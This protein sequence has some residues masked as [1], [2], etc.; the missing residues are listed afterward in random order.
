MT[1]FSIGKKGESPKLFTKNPIYSIC[2]KYRELRLTLRITRP[3]KASQAED[4]RFKEFVGFLV[5]EE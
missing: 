1:C 3:Q 2:T 4:Q 5:L